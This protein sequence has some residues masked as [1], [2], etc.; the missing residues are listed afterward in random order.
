MNKKRL[1]IFMGLLLIC[2]SACANSTVTENTNQTE[3]Q[4]ETENIKETENVKE[5]ENVTETKAV[6]EAENMT[7]T[8]AVQ[9][10][11]QPVV[12]LPEDVI[13]QYICEQIGFGG[14]FTLSIQEDGTFYYYEG[15]LSSYFGNG[16]WKIENQELILSENTYRYLQETVNTYVFTCY[17]GELVYNAQRSDPFMYVELNDGVRFIAEDQF[18]QQQQEILNQQLEEQLQ[19]QKAAMEALREETADDGKK[20]AI[21]VSTGVPE[22]NIALQ[23]GV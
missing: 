16:T 11:Q 21:E 7:E 5:A 18:T 13:N 4:A 9:E 14:M 2:F 8:E 15:S 23:G 19:E 6:T 20:I 22:L 10:K 12:V 1:S 17:Q 3:N